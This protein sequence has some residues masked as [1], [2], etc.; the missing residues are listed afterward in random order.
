VKIY[1][2]ASVA[3]T[4]YYVQG[5]ERIGPVEESELESLVRAG[6]LDEESYVWKRGFDNWARLKGVSELAY[7]LQPAQPAPTPMRTPQFDAMPEAIEEE[8]M[9]GGIDWRDYDPDLRNIAIKVGLDR[10][11]QETE[12]GP[13]SI[14]QLKLAFEQRR[15]NEKTYVFAPG[16]ESWQLIGETD[17]YQVLAGELPPTI[18]E[19]D[20]RQAP[21]KPFVARLF[22]H[23]NSQVYEGVCRDISVGGLQVLVSDFPAKV[24]E[25]VSLNVH[26]ENTE[27]HFVASGEVVRV[28]DG[29]A[30][31]SLRFKDLN[32]QAM[33]AIESYISG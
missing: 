33:A 6:T 32:D 14:D 24:G 7:I 29:G 2:G 15:I 20:K 4:W 12:Y 22:F 21:R 26:P 10:G 17:L 18:E 13:F 5:S 9:S 8:G 31:F 11:G 23:D 1:K 27:Y 25:K 30:G 3:E 16:M 19:V 28:L